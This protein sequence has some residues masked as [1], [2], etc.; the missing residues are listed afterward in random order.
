MKTRFPQSRRP[1]V[2]PAGS[3]SRG[4]GPRSGGRSGTAELARIV[5]ATDDLEHALEALER[6]PGIR[7]AVLGELRHRRP[8]LDGPS[9][10]STALLVRLA[11]RVGGAEGLVALIPFLAD[12]NPQVQVEAA[13]AVDVVPL[14]ELREVLER[15][16]RELPEGDFW[17]A[18]IGLLES[19]EER[20]IARVAAGLTERLTGPGPLAAVLEALP[21]LGRPE[22][23][24]LVKRT[25][26]RFVRD[27]RA[28]PGAETDEG[29]VTV[30]FVAAEALEALADAVP[31]TTDEDGGR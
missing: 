19:R 28:V 7:E 31:E 6:A 14:N 1:G 12:G 30:A 17:D 29:P 21:Y 25:L 9:P 18:V 8:G 2:E 13:E 4:A 26:R 16:A 27:S 24:P 23:V 20:G 15:V 22:D 5:A 3:T 10:W 11:G